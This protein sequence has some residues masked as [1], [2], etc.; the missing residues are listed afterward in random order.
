MA[1]SVVVG[2]QMVYSKG[3]GVREIGGNEPVTPETVFQV[4]SISKSF[5]A[6]LMGQ[7][8]EQ[9]KVHWTDP[10]LETVP[11]FQMYDPWVTRNFTI[12]DTMS[13]R[14]GLEA[15][16]G[17]ILV[18][19]GATRETIIESLRYTKPVTSFRSQ[20]AY[21]N[22]IWLVA[23]KVIETVTGKTWEDNVEQSIFQPLGMTQSSASLEEF[24]SEPNHATPHMRGADGPTPKK[25]GYVFADGVYIYGP[26]GGI[27][28]NVLDMARYA[29]MQLH[30]TLL[31]QATL[32]Y[33]HSPHIYAGGSS[34]TPAA[35]PGDLGCTSYCLGWLRQEVIPQPLV[36]HNG[37]THG[38]HGLIALIPDS[39]VAI[40]VLT[41]YSDTLLPEALMYKFY[42][43]YLDRPE[44]D[45][46][47]D[48]LITHLA[49]RPTR[50]QRPGKASPPSA[51]SNYAGTYHQDVY[52]TVEVR[53][54]GDGLRASLPPRVEMK[55]EPW[56]RDTFI[57]EDMT[58]PAGAPLFATFHPDEQG[59]M[60]ALKI[61]MFFSSPGGLFLRTAP[62]KDVP[63]AGKLP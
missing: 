14:S 43:L 34:K 63:K 25:K 39:D 32:D 29:R 52:G 17:D 28:S 9:E 8:V 19:L 35:D 55:L 38:S 58:N 12:E 3:F 21:M 59:E 42:D 18:I 4:G 13:Q 62:K 1:I 56:N 23:G 37:G 45:Y 44:Q 16:A 46:S 22:T 36:W 5:T 30:G 24:L 11:S 50:P 15:Y 57:F 40:V 33:M 47:S 6:A 7:L 2:D 60:S 20:F 54:E 27:N 26:C 53:V 61:D 31:S 10:V 41:N 49:G 48:F 51:L